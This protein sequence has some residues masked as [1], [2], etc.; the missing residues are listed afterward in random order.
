MY[1][2]NGLDT[3]LNNNGNNNSFNRYFGQLPHY[4]LIKVNGE[5][6]AKA[7]RM[8]PNSSL[9][10]ADANNPNLLW[11]VQTDGAGYQ[12]A[13]PLDVFIHQEKQQPTTSDLEERIKRLEELYDRLN[14][15]LS[16][17]SKKR[18]SASI[19]STNTT[20]DTTN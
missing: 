14:T 2:A 5:A 11:L 12:T 20:V 19:E 16:K 9:I 10:L 1:N 13:T 3:I 7:F 15:G 6:G 17:Q 18:Q 8:A 4:E